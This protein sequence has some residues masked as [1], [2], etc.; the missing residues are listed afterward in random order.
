MNIFI[1][2]NKKLSKKKNPHEQK[3]KNLVEKCKFS[4]LR[5]RL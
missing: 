5:F 1:I 2:V 4:Y 3:K